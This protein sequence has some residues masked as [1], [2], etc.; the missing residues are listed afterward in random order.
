MLEPIEPA[1]IA[2]RVD[3]VFSALP[4]GAS[5]TVAPALLAGG[6]LVVDLAGDFRLPAEDYPAWY[7]FEHPAPDWLD[8]AVYGLPELFGGAV[9]GAKLVASPGCFPTPAILGLGP[10][11]AAG[12]L[13]PGAD[14]GR[15]EDRRLRRRAGGR[16]GDV[17]RRHR[18]RDPPVP[19]PRPPAHAG[20]R[21]R[22]RAGLGTRRP[23]PVRAAPR[24]DG[25]RRR[26]HGVRAARGR[27][28]RRGAHVLP[29]GRLR[30]PAVRPGAARGGDGRREAH[31]RHERR[32]AAGVRRPADR[33]RRRGRRPRQPRS[34]A[35]PVRRS[36]T[37][38]CSW[39]CPRRPA[40]RSRRCSRER[41]RDLSRGVP[42][43]RRERGREA[44][45]RRRPRPAR[46]RRPARRWRDCSRRT[47]SWRRP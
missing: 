12:L 25:A 23:R 35:R 20:D 19:R 45:R 6:A 38:T 18:G 46:R 39:G 30:R 16:R 22:A 5:S 24:A 21:A 4:N 36:R 7:G 37:R 47:A 9:A 17:V 31:A 8:E 3:L 32:G 15:R 33:H 26:H 13:E 40:C 14:P 10:L 41:G 43:R 11:L 42:G 28:R 29:R 27:R 44:E 1:S 2:E 34:R